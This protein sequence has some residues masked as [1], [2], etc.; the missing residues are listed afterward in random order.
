MTRTMEE[1]DKDIAEQE[2]KLAALKIEREG[3]W[4]KVGDEVFLLHNHGIITSI[5]WSAAP[6]HVIALKRRGKVF[7]TREEAE[8]ADAQDVIL[9]GIHADAKADR[10]KNPQKI[11]LD[12]YVYTVNNS[13][14]S[15]T[16][17]P[18]CEIPYGTPYFHTSEAAAA[19]AE[20]WIGGE[21]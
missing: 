10:E 6:F 13:N 1:V 9:A 21:V 15:F 5:H 14:G 7:R 17:I 12:T 19:S 3:I 20:K 2:A 18:R 4:P 8:A 16:G 11:D